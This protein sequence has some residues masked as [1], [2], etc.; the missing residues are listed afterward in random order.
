MIKL[1]DV[2]EQLVGGIMNAQEKARHAKK[3]KKLKKATKKQG[4][5][6]MKYPKLPK[7]VI[8]V[9]IEPSNYKP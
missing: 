9:K 5:E 3:L 1:L 6:Y 2:L 4:S 8:G 7:T